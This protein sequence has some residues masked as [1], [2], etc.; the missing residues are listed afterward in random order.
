MLVLC[1]L[2]VV[3]QF[4]L[5]E[6]FSHRQTNAQYAMDILDE[7]LKEYQ[8]AQR[9]TQLSAVIRKEHKR[10]YEKQLLKAIYESNPNYEEAYCDDHEITCADSQFAEILFIGYLSEGG[11]DM[12]DKLHI[13]ELPKS[14]WDADHNRYD[15]AF[16]VGFAGG[17]L[18]TTVK[19]RLSEEWRQECSD[20]AIE[21]KI[22]GVPLRIDILC[23]PR[24]LRFNEIDTKLAWAG[25]DRY[26]GDVRN[27]SLIAYY[28]LRRLVHFESVMSMFQTLFV[29]I[30]LGL[31]AT[32]FNKDSKELV[33]EPIERMI[34]KMHR[35][36]D[37]PLVAMRL[38]DE[39]FH[40]QQIA[41]KR[42]L[43]MQEVSLSTGYFSWWRK[44]RSR[45]GLEAK[46]KRKVQEPMETVIL[47]STLIKLGGLLA[48][49]FGVA[50]AEIIGQNL[51][52]DAASVNAMVPGVKIEA[53]FGFCNIHHFSEA[54]EI[55]G[56]RIMIYVNQVAE[57]V[58]SLTDMFGGNANKNIGDAFLL[59]WKIATL[60][61]DISGELEENPISREH[62]LRRMR[63]CDMSVVAFCFTISAI[64][65][66]AIL[67]EYRSHPGFLARFPNYRVQMGFGLHLGYAIEGAIGS[68][69]KIDA[70]YLSPNVNMASRL[71]SACTQYG[72]HLL[73]SHFL[74][75]QA[76]GALRDACRQI[77]RV[78]VK[79]SKKPVGL[80]TCDFTVGVLHVQD[81]MSHIDHKTFTVR[82]KYEVRQIRELKKHRKW[83]DDYEPHREL[84]EDPEIMPMREA[85]SKEFFQRFAMAFR[86]YI[87]GEWLVAREMLQLTKTMLIT[88]DAGAKRARLLTDMPSATLLHFMGQHNYKAPAD[89]DGCRSLTS[90]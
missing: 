65:K 59:V 39:E 53:I 57:V 44:L 1:M 60:P 38:G 56:D 20:D 88:R 67:A 23:P 15:L 26:T 81:L 10:Q 80:Y 73:M 78:Y 49:G 7:F 14:S 29:C 3:P 87:A 31:T 34:A 83:A 76:S 74:L 77:D 68:E 63:M 75:D 69:F 6:N 9:D 28:D 4:Q 61:K 2:L 71:E 41:L 46:K 13:T 22:I 19:T 37:N 66:S 12:R 17:D 84:L 79:G 51:S 48:V 18:P 58:H 33:L 62:R 54:T 89:W 5:S 72:V 27:D 86:N 64:N 43:E 90:K 45:W 35:I 11:W 36:R 42:D 40:Q 32:F 25:F 24:K 30:V 16:E 85:F 52:G 8:T 70:S 50:G 21:K 47:E 55:L 82:R